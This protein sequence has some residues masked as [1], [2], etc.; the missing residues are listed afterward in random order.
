[1][2]M[3]RLQITFESLIE[4]IASLSLEEKH[5]LLEILEE[6]VLSAEE[7]LLEQ[8]VGNKNQFNLPELKKNYFVKDFF[9]E[10]E[11]R[12]INWWKRKF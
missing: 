4:A 7:D 8:K 9:S 6:Q 12:K 5:Q 11:N 3:I 10:S 1:M 2:T